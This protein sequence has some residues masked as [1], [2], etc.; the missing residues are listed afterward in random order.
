MGD[1]GDRMPPA[2]FPSNSPA[3]SPANSPLAKLRNFSPW[4]YWQLRLAAESRRS[5]DGR[6]S[7]DQLFELLG[8]TPEP[9]PLDLEVT[10]S[11]DCGSYRRDRLVFDTEA[12]MS[13]PAFLLVPHE[14]TTIG[15]AVVAI[16]GHG[17]GKAMACGIDDGDTLRRSEIDECRG[18]YAH[19][20]AR[21]GFV[22]LAPDLRAFG[23]RQDPQWDTHSHKY[24][25]DWNLVCAVMAGTNP[26]AQNL[27]D[28][29][30]CVDVL[31]EHPLV[32]P[33]RV[34]VAGFSYGGTMAL[35]L[36]AIDD[37]IRAAVVS[38]Y[39]S[40]WAA[41]HRVPWNMCGSQVMWGQLGAVEHVDLA[42]LVLPRA[43]LVESGTHDDIFPVESA[44]QTIAALRSEFGD[45]V[46]DSNLVHDVFE[47]AHRWNGDIAYDFLR[48]SLA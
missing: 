10:N 44:R 41:A 30:R 13:V 38:G 28:L 35:L 25:C 17:P 6:I 2:D 31:T 26:V 29:Q 46:T 1:Y 18:D 34:G 11:I 22:V 8:P 3:D 32:D 20:L 45:A 14:R 48:D 9:V 33:Q 47:G 27:W 16:H 7:R 12:G 36:A 21:R 37:R 19:E 40:S 15:A 39:L 24:D 42:A 5:L 4:A 43:L 23:E